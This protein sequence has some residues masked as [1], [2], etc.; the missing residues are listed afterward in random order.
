VENNSDET[1]AEITLM[2]D[3]TVS[4]NLVFLFYFQSIVFFSYYISLIFW[5]C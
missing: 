4:E 3:T 1:Y 2:P 5:F